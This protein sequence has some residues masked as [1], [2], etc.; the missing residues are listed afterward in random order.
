[1]DDDRRIAISKEE[2]NA[3]ENK[4]SFVNALRNFA[5]RIE[6]GDKTCGFVI[7]FV[8]K[9]INMGLEGISTKK[10]EIMASTFGTLQNQI[11]LVLAMPNV[12]H[13]AHQELIKE[14]RGALKDKGEVGG[15]LGDALKDLFKGD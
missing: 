3:E 6:S 2:Q 15:L 9:D 1:M 7:A 12:V 14:I 10:S 8:T 4:K 13:S 11:A 5:D